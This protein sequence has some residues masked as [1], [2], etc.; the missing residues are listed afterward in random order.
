MLGGIPGTLLGQEHIHMAENPLAG[1]RVFG[2]KGCVKCHSINGLGGT[3]GPD[4]GGI[5]QAGSFYELAA[6]MWNHVPGM[7]QRMTEYGIERSPMSPP[8]RSG[9]TVAAGR[10]NCPPQD[11]C[12]LF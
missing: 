9:R 11:F 12:I 7:T 3:V 8:A 5:S 2:E 4:L 6:T 10:T 1:S